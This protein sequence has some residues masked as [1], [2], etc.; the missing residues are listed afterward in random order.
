MNRCETRAG[1]TA[2][3][4][5]LVAPV[6]FLIMFAAIEF[7]RVSSIRHTAANAAYEGARTGI[8]PGASAQAVM[9]S[10]EEV[11]SAVHVQEADIDV[12]PDEITE[13]TPDVTVQVTIPLNK[14][15]WLPPVFFVD[16]EVQVSCKL[17]REY[18]ESVITP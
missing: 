13:E 5:A 4:L 17:Q 16:K 3:E 2:V 7:A 10:A 15:C 8:L 14:N 1:T 9:T 12:E 18:L 11:L 6:L